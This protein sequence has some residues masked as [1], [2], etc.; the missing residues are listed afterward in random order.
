[1]VKLADVEH[2]ISFV[3]KTVVKMRLINNKGSILF[4]LTMY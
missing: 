2:H 3:G 1:M 4:D